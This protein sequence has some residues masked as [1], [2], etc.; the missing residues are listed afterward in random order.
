MPNYICLG[1]ASK[2]LL[3]KKISPN[4]KNWKFVIIIEILRNVRQ[5]RKSVPTNKRFC[6]PKV[7]FKVNVEHKNYDERPGF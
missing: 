7:K 5:R 1:Q 6:I 2:Y 4:D 3:N